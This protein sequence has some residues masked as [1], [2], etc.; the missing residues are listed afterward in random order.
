[1]KWVI[2]VFRVLY[3]AVAVFFAVA[4]VS[5]VV[6]AVVQFWRSISA[7]QPA[8]TIEGIALLAVALVALEIAQTRFVLDTTRQIVEQTESGEEAEPRAS[9]GVCILPAHDEADQLT[10][11]ML[12]RLL[13]GAKLLSSESLAGETLESVSAQDC[14][15]I[16]IAAVPPN[17]ASHAAYLARRLKQRFPEV[18]I[19]VAYWTTESIDKLKPRLLGAGVDE[20]VTRLP[21]ALARLRS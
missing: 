14:R 1:M 9:P 2:P 7:S 17:A 11:A 12:A 19:V 10:G 6:F 18:R 15:A 13:P 20:V 21:D 3:A 16:C 5:L 8:G 4:G